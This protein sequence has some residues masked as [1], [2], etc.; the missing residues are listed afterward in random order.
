MYLN[1]DK[2]TCLALCNHKI[3][4]PQLYKEI[5]RPSKE[6]YL[7]RMIQQAPRIIL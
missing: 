1:K 3:L 4:N 2:E 5:L 7:K 6:Q